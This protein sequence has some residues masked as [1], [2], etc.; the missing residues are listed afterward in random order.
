MGM[1]VDLAMGNQLPDYIAVNTK[2]RT[3]T[4]SQIET[5]VK[6]AYSSKNP[7]AKSGESKPE[8]E[9]E[10]QACSGIALKRIKEVENRLHGKFA[11]VN[12]LFCIIEHCQFVLTPLLLWKS[13]IHHDIFT[14]LWN[15]VICQSKNMI[16]MK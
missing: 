6:T 11:K 1:G 16:F 9:E 5:A 13:W 12:T 14:I 15:E 8:D 3:A 10:I 2:A 7:D 4:Q